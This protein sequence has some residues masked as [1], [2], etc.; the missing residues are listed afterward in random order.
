MR[1]AASDAPTLVLGPIQDP[2]VELLERASLLLLQHPIAAQAAFRALVEEGRRFAATEEGNRWF[3]RLS[4]AEAIQR[5]RV[6]WEDSLLNILEDSADTLLPSVIVDALA[7]AVR[8]EDPHALL[9]QLFRLP[10]A[11][12]RPS[13]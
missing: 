8:S 13:R 6:L 10:D 2:L 5:G 11:D 7:R 3:R 4:H 9:A 1:R 12:A